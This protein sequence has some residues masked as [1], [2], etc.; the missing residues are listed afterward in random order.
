MCPKG[1][2]EEISVLNINGI[3]VTLPEGVVC[4]DWFVE[5]GTDSMP[6]A[7]ADLYYPLWTEVSFLRM[8]WTI[9]HQ[10]FGTGASLIVGMAAAPA[11]FT[12]QPGV[13]RD[14]ITMGISRLTD[15]TTI[16]RRNNARENLTLS[17]LVD[18]IP[19]H[20]VDE[21]NRKS[22][23]KQLVQEAYT[24]SAPLREHRNRRIAH[25]DMA[26]LL[27]HYRALT[28]AEDEE[29]NQAIEAVT[30]VLVA[31]D[32]FYK[33]DFATF[34]DI[35]MHGDGNTVM[36]LLKTGLERGMAETV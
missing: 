33:G 3:N 27:D 15:R 9:Y 28:P 23:V 18:A 19:A 36:R 26:T 21:V 10:M 25:N 35:S 32:S 29:M 30:N 20:S 31:V 1:Q 11:F 13:Y 7:V 22:R 2:E 16:G 17:V 34:G 14:Y 5:G 4:F 24:N 6:D 8:A 12:I